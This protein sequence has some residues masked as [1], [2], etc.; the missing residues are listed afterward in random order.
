MSRTTR[1][2]PV[3]IAAALGGITLVLSAATLTLAQ[4]EKLLEQLRQML[5]TVAGVKKATLELTGR[6]PVAVN[7]ATAQDLAGE[8]GRP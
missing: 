7:D 8:S 3:S 4:A 5:S 6:V 2:D 1:F